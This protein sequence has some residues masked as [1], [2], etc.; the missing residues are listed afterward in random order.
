M[1]RYLNIDFDAKIGL[2]VTTRGEGSSSGRQELSMT[3]DIV[4]LRRVRK[5]RARRDEAA[6]AAEN[7]IRFGRTKA[8]RQAADADAR[9]QAA[10]L[11]ALQRDPRRG[12]AQDEDP[13]P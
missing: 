11:D 2:A 6:K 7:R 4:N 13:S 5:A 8:E 10:R 12:D 1:N 9:R 3:A